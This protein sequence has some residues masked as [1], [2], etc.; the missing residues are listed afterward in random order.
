MGAGAPPPAVAVNP[1]GT[2]SALAMMLPT[3]T[4]DAMKPKPATTAAM[5]RKPCMD[6]R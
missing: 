2:N 6:G 5:L 1:A 3:I 4:V